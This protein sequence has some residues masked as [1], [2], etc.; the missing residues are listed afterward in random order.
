M[1][2]DLLANTGSAHEVYGPEPA[3]PIAKS[4]VKKKIR[5]WVSESKELYWRNIDYARH[6]KA[7]IIEI[8]FWTLID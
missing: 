8:I 3:L 7:F 1:E 4:V 6:T 5:D 2:A